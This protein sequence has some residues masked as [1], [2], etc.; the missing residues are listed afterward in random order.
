M[1]IRDRCFNRG[2]ADVTLLNTFKRFQETRE[3]Y[4]IIF[5]DIDKFKEYNDTFGHDA[6]DYV[7]KPVSYTHLRLSS[8]K[9]ITK[10]MDGKHLFW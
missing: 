3:Q 9:E 5:F 1:C 10:W 6:G 8:D 7:L 2:S 4:M